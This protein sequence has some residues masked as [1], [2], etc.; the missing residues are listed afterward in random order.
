MDT[1]DP[2]ILKT[3]SFASFAAEFI[4]KKIS[5]TLKIQDRFIL[6]LSGGTTP[7]SVYEEIAKIGQTLDW[8]KVIVTFSDERCVGPED[9]DSNFR[10]A[11]ESLL[12]AISIPPQ[13]IHRI[14]GELSPEDAAKKYEGELHTANIASHDLLLLGIGDDGHTAS[15]FPDNM[16]LSEDTRFVVATFIPKLNTYRITLTY[17]SINASRDICF[18]V[19][20]S[21]K[22]GVLEKIFAGNIRYPAAAVHAQENTYWIIGQNAKI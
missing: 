18:L 16:S 3:E 17:P 14:H 1:T 8:E 19:N 13:N 15:L 11:K 21:K 7:K 12:D 6:G 5:E 9:P 2:I 10:M 22:E 20:D 4:I